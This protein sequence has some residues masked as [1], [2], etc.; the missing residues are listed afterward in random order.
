MALVKARIETE[1]RKGTPVSETYKIIRSMV[2]NQ[3]LAAAS[4]PLPA[5]AEAPS[6]EPGE[7][8]AEPPAKLV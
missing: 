5:E 1:F 6:S 3:A 7:D 2:A 4:E 8:A